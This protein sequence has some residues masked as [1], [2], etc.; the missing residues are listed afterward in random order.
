MFIFYNPFAKPKDCQC[1]DFC[2]LI[3]QC[4]DCD[5]VIDDNNSNNVF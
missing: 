1:C 2:E 4:E 5:F 3:C